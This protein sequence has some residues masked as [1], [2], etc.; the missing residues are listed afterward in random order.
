MNR[1]LTSDLPEGRVLV[2][3]ALTHLRQLPT[4]SVDT[5]MTSPAYFRLRNY[6]VRDQ[7]GAEDTVEDWA[8][9]LGQVLAE[10]ARVLKP[11]GALWLN[12]GDSYSR[13]AEQGAPPKSLVLG[14]ERV[15]LDLVRSG[16]TVRNKVVWAKPN[17]MPAS[18]RDRLA[19]TWEPLYLLVRSTNYYFDLDAIRERPRSKLKGPSNSGIGSKY[20]HRGPGRPAWSGPAAGTNSG[21]GLMKATGQT[22]HPLGKNPGDVWQLPTAAYRGAHF[23]TFPEALVERPLLATCP[24]RVCLTCGTAWRRAPTIQRLGTLA[25]RSVLRKSCGCPSRDWQPG[26]VLDPFMGSGTVGVVAEQLQRRWLGI[27]LNPAYAKQSDQRIASARAK[28]TWD[29]KQPR[30]EETTS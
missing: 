23:A 9:A 6:G 11:A 25:V 20:G 29:I 18:V 26:L 8:E 21:L 15:L 28:K 13:R 19:C 10:I 1:Q 30:K 5:V 27:E 24:E 3:D 14:P 17:P 2:G 22:S 4:A 7:L 16:W 12:L